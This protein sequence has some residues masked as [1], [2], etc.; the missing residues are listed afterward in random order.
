MF[1]PSSS[2]IKT[3]YPNY[4]NIRDSIRVRDNELSLPTDGNG[5]LDLS[6]GNPYAT[7]N[8]LPEAYIK[9]FYRHEGLD[10]ATNG[11]MPEIAHLINIGD[12]AVV[13]NLGNLEM[14]STK[15]ELLNKSKPLPPFLFAHNHQTK[16]TMMF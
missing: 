9:G 3:G 13:T 12:L 14:P 8:S 15:E 11:L 16:L 10:I 5:N 7:N 6:S 4:A 2:D 1:I